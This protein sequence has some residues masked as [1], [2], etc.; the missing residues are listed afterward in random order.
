MFEAS[1]DDGL[2]TGDLVEVRGPGEILATLDADGALD[3]LPFMPEMSSFCG[4][5][6]RVLRRAEKT[7]VEMPLGRYAINEFR[8]NDVVVLEL[9]RC[10][11]ADHDGCQRLC[12]LFWK[13]AWLRKIGSSA[14]QTA[15]T[16]DPAATVAL[17]SRLKTR[18]DG[19][20][21]FCQSTELAKATQLHDKIENPPEMSCRYSFWQPRRIRDGVVDHQAAL[22]QGH[23]LVSSPATHGSA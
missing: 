1:N 11:G 6:V 16:V 18:L 12:T 13:A 2:R 22:A 9:P 23:R 3:G 19:G 21:Y 15:S 5:R 8:R 20:R 4:Q 17:R 10:S 7:C 14:V